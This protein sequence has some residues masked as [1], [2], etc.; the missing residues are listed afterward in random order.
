[1]GGAYYRAEPPLPPKE[2]HAW[3]TPDQLAAY[4][5]VLLILFEEYPARTTFERLD[6]ELA[7]EYLERGTV[8]TARSFAV[9]GGVPQ[10]RLEAVH[11][12]LF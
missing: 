1:M 10:E 2:F 11:A 5:E 3:P 6:R 9:I 8:N 12:L 7:L 4:R